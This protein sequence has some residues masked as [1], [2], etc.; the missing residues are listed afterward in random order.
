LV[1]FLFLRDQLK[2]KRKK[3]SMARKKGILVFEMPHE[4]LHSVH[5]PNMYTRKQFRGLKVL[6]GYHTFMIPAGSGFHKV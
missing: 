4:H 2:E 3:N 5:V 6:G 1:S